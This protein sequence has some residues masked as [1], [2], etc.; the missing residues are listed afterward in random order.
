MPEFIG[1]GGEYVPEFIGR[2]GEYVPERWRV[3]T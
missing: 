1:R 3:C 2:G